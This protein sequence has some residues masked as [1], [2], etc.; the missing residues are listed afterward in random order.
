MESL[1]KEN[2]WDALEKECPD[3]V[4]E[5]CTWIDEYKKKN[6][7]DDLFNKNYRMEGMKFRGVK[8]HDI[9]IEMQ[10]GILMKY[11]NKVYGEGD[12]FFTDLHK[13]ITELFK[14]RQAKMNEKK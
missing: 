8:F 2:F 5:F 11:G 3:S 12:S 13:L 7:W 10:S 6:N 14:E 1:T 4:K 9:P